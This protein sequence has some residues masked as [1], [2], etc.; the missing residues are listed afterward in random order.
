MKNTSAKRTLRIKVS[1]IAVERPM[2]PCA[3]VIF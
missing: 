1:K 2:L 3:A